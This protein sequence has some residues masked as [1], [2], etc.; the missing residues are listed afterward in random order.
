MSDSTPEN[1]PTPDI[2][3]SPTAKA[4][5]VMKRSPEEHWRR[6][7]S[8]SDPMR[9]AGAALTLGRLAAAK[10]DLEEAV[11]LLGRAASSR[12]PT[13]TPRAL[14]Q[15]AAGRTRTRHYTLPRR[16]ATLSTRLT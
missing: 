7:L 11:R 3:L 14:V 4:R 16:A 8:N 5:A 9:E 2:P 6:E 13:V 12:E 15:M 1:D 10:G